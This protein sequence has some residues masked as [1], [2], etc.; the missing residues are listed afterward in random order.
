MVKAKLTTTLFVPVLNEIDGI[1]KVMPKIDSN[2]VDQILIV[3]GGSKDGTVEYARKKGYSVI[4][5]KKPGIRNAYIEAL[6][7]MKGEV[8]VAF[9]PDGN[10]VPENIPLLI[11]KIQ[12]GYDM[13]IAS[14]F[15]KGAKSYDDNSLTAFGNWGFTFLTNLIHGA[16][17]T[18]VLN[19]FRAF[20]KSM[21]SDLDLDKEIS[22][23]WEEAL[24]RTKICIIPLMSIR[25]AKRKLNVTEIPG[26]EPARVGGK[27]KLQPFR[28]G[29]AYLTQI[30]REKFYWR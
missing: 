17:Y 16:K 18:D 8:I 1:K 24:F 26:D 27:A 14:R 5:Q 10:C 11:E 30:L 13:V 9:S 4:I 19:M 12:Q 3:D 29:A 7:Y 28:W 25:S 21:I 2:W 15:M 6:P 23:C 20:K 22:Y